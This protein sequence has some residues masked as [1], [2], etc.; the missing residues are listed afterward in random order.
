MCI[1]VLNSFE[2]IKER[3]YYIHIIGMEA[4]AQKN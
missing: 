4:E 3:D 2:I 1:T